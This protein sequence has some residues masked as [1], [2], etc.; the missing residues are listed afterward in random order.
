MTPRHCLLS[1]VIPFLFSFRYSGDFSASFQSPPTGHSTSPLPTSSPQHHPPIL[2][3]NLT[4]T[5]SGS[6]SH[7]PTLQPNWT[8]S[9]SPQI[10]TSPSHFSHPPLSPTYSPYPT[11]PKHRTKYRGAKIFDFQCTPGPELRSSMSRR[12][13]PS[14]LIYSTN[15]PSPAPP[16]PSSLP[17]LPST[18]IYNTPF[19]FLNPLTPSSPGHTLGDAYNPSTPPLFPTSPQPPSAL[20]VSRSL[21]PTQFLSGASSP[22]MHLPPSPSCLSYPHH[23]PPPPAK[24]FTIKPLS[25]WTKWDVADWLAYLNLGE[26]RERFLDNEI[27]GSHLPSLT[28]DDFLDLGVTRVGHRMNIER[29]LKTLTD[30]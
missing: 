14:P 28:K 22:S 15:R 30:R 26:H 12:R 21:S 5:P 18:H 27:D 1:T 7:Q 3:P 8:R 6:P 23:T 4:A 20:L 2:T 29:A 25:Y 19:D 13:A 24:P 17:I 16:R 11:S 10:P 9:P